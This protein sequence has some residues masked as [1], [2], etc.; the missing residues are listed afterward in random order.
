MSERAHLVAEAFG[1]WVLAWTLVV[2]AVG[3][4]S[5]VF[6]PRRASVR[7]GGWLLATFA[8]AALL[9][10]VVAVGPRVSWSEVIL[11][12]LPAAAVSAPQEPSSSS[13]SWFADLP[14]SVRPE[15]MARSADPEDPRVASA[16]RDGQ[17][18]S[19]P[20]APADVPQPARDRWLTLALGVWFAGFLAFGA[21]LIRS[22]LR[23]GAT[24]ARLDLVVP[25]ELEIEKE[26]IRHELGIRR[27]VRIATHPEI[28]APMCVGLLRPVVL[29]PSSENCPMNPRQRL[30]SLT[31]ELA[32][33][34]HGDDWVALLAEL[35][36][37]L[38]WFFLPVHLAMRFLHREREYRCDDL[39]AVAMETPEDYACWLLDL[40]PVCVKSPPPLL[41]AS[42]LGRTSLAGRIGRIARGELR[43]AR[44]IGRRRWAILIL[45]AILM[46]GA[47]GSVRL[48]GF[49]GRARAAEPMDAPL[50]EMTPRELA[51]R[52]REAMKPYDDK[53]LFRVVFSETRDTN[54]KFNLNRGTEEEQKPILVTFHGRA[55]YES[56]GRLWR[57]EY[58]AMTTSSASTRL[59][60]DRW[61]T[62]F[63]GIQLYDRKV[64]HN[65]VILGEANSSAHEW[66][67]RS[68][69]WERSENLVQVLE[70]TGRDKLSIG[71]EQRVVDGLRCYV[72]K[73]G[74][75]GATWGEETFISPRQGYLPVR[76]TQTGNGQ[77]SVS[78]ELHDLHEAAPGIWAP[79]QIDYEWLNIRNDGA[80]RLHLRRRI[81]VAAYQPGAIVPPTAFALDVPYSVDVTDRRSGTTYHNDPW[82]PEIGAMLREK[83][84]WPK[85]DLS[86]LA[87]LGS[88]SDKKIEN[89]PALP[90]HV[91]HWL[92]SEPRDLAALRGKVVLLEFWNIAAPFHR[93]LVP[94][95]KK[96]YATYHPA[97]LEMI[98]VHVPTDDPES[99]RRFIQEYGIDYPVAIDAKGPEFWGATAESYGS[100]DHTCA[101]LIDREGK[102]HS[103][104]TE[105]FNGGRIVETLLPLLKEAGAGDLKPISLET[106]RLPNDAFKA[107]INLFAKKVQESLDA[108]PPGRIRFRIIDEHGQPIVGAKVKATLGFTVL[109]IGTPGSYHAGQYQP[110]L[111]RFRGT[112]GPDGQLELQGLCKGAYTIKAEAPGKAWVQRKVIVTP[113]LDP[114]SVDIVMPAGL[115]ITGQVRD[116]RG[117]PIPGATLSATQWELEEDGRVTTSS[118][119]DWLKPARA[120]ADGRFRF[121]DLPVAR[122]TFEVNAPGFQP[123][124]LKKVPAGTEELK[125][126]LKKSESR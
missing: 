14:A 87:H 35:W 62:G 11:P 5:V 51:A 17:P 103:V 23:I 76:R 32:H 20:V 31:H 111:E 65:Q 106:A 52:I 104:G 114:A 69:F 108:D 3:L 96:L 40:A 53:G 89:Q 13:R 28:A 64:W 82:W 29:W 119:C 107:C 57:A 90:L 66:T 110:P 55:R 45:A 38:A 99:V 56:N 115:T 92:N 60:P 1:H 41:A 8:G 101:F 6:R 113:D 85:L 21:R 74:K 63:D 91:A 25:G 102:L 46:L 124:E 68:L 77:R 126:T 81:R 2:L 123:M 48:V 36:R 16:S 61:T 19:T 118:E 86:A 59:T 39:A 94:A 67:P 100:R 15:L 24:L 95:M 122:Y 93:P 75:P 79:G 7:Y 72:V 105:T 4:W 78:Y 83:Y 125:P 84:D 42:L 112:T 43:W 22:G 116:D 44:P 50:P 18:A 33:L 71:I 12:L 9:P 80:S 54:W 26:Q 120:D 58:D 88:P 117:K 49:A 10:M 27:R 98:A 73:V 97:G 109:S 34:R 121:I 30:A 47:A 70:E 37:A